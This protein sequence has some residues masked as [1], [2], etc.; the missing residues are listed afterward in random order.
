M[1]PTKEAIARE[2][3]DQIWHPDF[4]GDCK[5]AHKMRTEKIIL[6]AIEKAVGQVRVTDGLGSLGKIQP[7]AQSARSEPPATPRMSVAT[8]MSDART[9]LRNAGWSDDDIFYVLPEQPPAT[10]SGQE[11][12][13]TES[14]VR[15]PEG[16]YL[17]EGDRDIAYFP[18]SEITKAYAI[19]DAHKAAIA[20]ERG[21]NKI[22]SDALKLAYEELDAAQAA[23]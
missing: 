2:A 17:M 20:A 5:T 14:N 6:A 8:A 11:W 15:S 4:N 21:R 12:T 9:V 13:I 10:E 22:Q 3:A 19:R 7:T 18:P 23:L 16:L 1:N